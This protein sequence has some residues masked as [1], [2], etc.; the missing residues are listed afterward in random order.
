[1]F[2]PFPG[3]PGSIPGVPVLPGVSLSSVLVVGSGDV[4]VAVGSHGDGPG[5][6]VDLMM[7]TAASEGQI[8][9]GSLATCGPRV[10]VVCFGPTGGPITAGEHAPAIPHGQRGPDV[11][12]DGSGGPPDIQRLGIRTHDQALHCRVTQFLQH[13]GP[14]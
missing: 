7:V 13:R 8:L 9:Y 6:G 1:M 14:G 4:G 12:W 10:D 2:P 3:C 11:R 5:A